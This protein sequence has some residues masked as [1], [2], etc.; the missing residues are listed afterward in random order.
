MPDALIVCQK[1]FQRYSRGSIDYERILKAL[2]RK[3]II[4][5]VTVK[6]RKVWGRHY[7]TPAAIRAAYYKQKRV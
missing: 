2:E 6:G 4:Q 7:L 3:G 1:D 5:A